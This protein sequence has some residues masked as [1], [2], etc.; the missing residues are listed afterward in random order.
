VL[1]LSII[2]ATVTTAM[3]AFAYAVRR[4]NHPAAPESV[5]DNPTPTV[6]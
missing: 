5:S 6:A 4:R 3:M 2:T 1:T